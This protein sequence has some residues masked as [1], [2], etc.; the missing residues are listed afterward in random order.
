MKGPQLK[1]HLVLSTLGRAI[2]ITRPNRIH[3]PSN[4]SP[5][6]SLTERTHAEKEEKE[7]RKSIHRIPKLLHNKL[8]RAKKWRVEA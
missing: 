8:L 2:S 3:I 4:E 7:K 6:F 1:R 5:P